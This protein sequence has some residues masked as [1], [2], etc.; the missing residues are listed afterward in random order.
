MQVTYHDLKKLVRKVSYNRFSKN[1]NHNTA[2]DVQD[3]AELSGYFLGMNIY[4]QRGSGD[5]HPTPPHS[6]YPPPPPSANQ[7]VQNVQ[8]I[9]PN[10]WQSP[11]NQIP[12][13]RK[14][15]AIRSLLVTCMF[16]FDERQIFL[17]PTDHVLRAS[18]WSGNFRWSESGGQ[19]AAASAAEVSNELFFQ[20]ANDDASEP[21]K[22][23]VTPTQLYCISTS[24]FLFCNIYN[25]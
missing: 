2:T 16:L 19:T 6:A 14:Y 1:I 3:M 17:A 24:S 21:S 7:S 12:V 25:N 5:S 15:H 10:Y 13:R 4:D 20:R 9:Q 18:T 8:S 11:P 23:Y 22:L